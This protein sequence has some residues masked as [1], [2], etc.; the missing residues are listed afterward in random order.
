MATLKQIK[1]NDV[2]SQLSFT[3]T[4]QDNTPINLSGA[5]VKVIIAGGYTYTKLER[6]CVVDSAVSGTCHYILVVAD[7]SVPGDYS[8]EVNIDYGGSEFTTITQGDLRI[9]DTL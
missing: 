4:D 8:I 1:K 7:T 5:T 9:I 3:L 6:T 2:G